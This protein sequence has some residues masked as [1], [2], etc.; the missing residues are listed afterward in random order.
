MEIEE[1]VAKIYRQLA[2]SPRLPA[3]L[4]RIL[5]ALA[6]EEDDHAMQLRFAKRFPTGTAVVEKETN[7]APVNE[8]LARAKAMLTM[9]QQK[10]CDVAQALDMGIELEQDFCQAHIANS[11]EFANEKLKQMFAALAK[12]D[13]AH[14]QKLLDARTRFLG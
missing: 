4:K 11:V 12:D 5:H 10:E 1:T 14:T 8:L 2:K 3:E 13:K 7:L 9:A 6:D